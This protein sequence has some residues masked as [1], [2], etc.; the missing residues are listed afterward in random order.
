MR[1]KLNWL[2]MVATATVAA[3]SSDS[4]SPSDGGGGGTPGTVT[5]GNIFFKSGNNGTQNPAIDTVAAG[6]TVTWTWTNTGDTPHSVQSQGSPSFTSS[7]TET[8]DGKTYTFAFMTP[9]TY[10]YDCLV[11]GSA[12]TGR[13]V[14]Q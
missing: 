7:A 11:H 10:Q 6:T 13:I 5:V 9:G 3:C 4:N 14:V 2:L 12:M 8:G 1:S